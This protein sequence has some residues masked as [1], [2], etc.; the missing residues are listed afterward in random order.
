MFASGPVTVAE[1]PDPTAAVK[2]AM[3][4]AA[5]DTS[6]AKIAPPARAR[7]A[8]ATDPAPLRSGAAGAQAPVR[9]DVPAKRPSG[10]TLR[11]VL[12][13]SVAAMVLVA[14]VLSLPGDLLDRIPGQATAPLTAGASLT[15]EEQLA[16]IAV[17]DGIA[18]QTVETVNGTRAVVSALP[19]GAETDLQ[20]GD[21]L[22]VYAATGEMIEN[23]EGA[24]ALLLRESKNGIAT[25]S[26]AVQRD[27][28]MAVGSI[29]LR[30]LGKADLDVKDQDLENK[31]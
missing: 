14:G 21:V 12:I 29:G 2:A 24:K 26:F 1:V 30:D 16:E 9:Q 15:V 20:V 10:G 5:R 17:V 23:A 11:K 25:F 28:K 18:L 31:T 8:A 13:A 22:L 6:V 19:D 27:G 4:E 7:A 3:A